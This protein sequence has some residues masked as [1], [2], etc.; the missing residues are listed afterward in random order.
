MNIHVFAYLGKML[1]CTKSKNY[2]GGLAEIDIMN[3]S[4]LIYDNSCLLYFVRLS[5]NLTIAWKLSPKFNLLHMLTIGN[6]EL[7]TYFDQITVGELSKVN[8]T[9]GF[10]WK[11]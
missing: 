2:G 4:E 1:A 10:Q 3:K 8:G 7:S 6:G 5:L 11:S 9:W